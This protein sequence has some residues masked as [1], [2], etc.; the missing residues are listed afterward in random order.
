MDCLR[1]R[2]A[3]WAFIPQRLNPRAKVL[4]GCAQRFSPLAQ[5]M[6]T[7]P[8]C[9]ARVR[10]D[11]GAFRFTPQ[12]RRF[13]PHTMW[14]FAK[15]RILEENAQ[16]T[17]TRAGCQDP[18]H[19]QTLPSAYSPLL[20]LIDYNISKVITHKTGKRSDHRSSATLKGANMARWLSLKCSVL[21][22]VLGAGS[23][24]TATG[25]DG[26]D[27]PASKPTA[28][29]TPTNPFAGKNFVWDLSKDQDVSRVQW[30][31]YVGGLGDIWFL[32]GPCT[33]TLILPDGRRGTFSLYKAQLRRYGA[34]I[35]SVSIE[36][37]SETLTESRDR[38]RQ[39][40]SDWQISDLRELERW[41][42]KRAIDGGNPPDGEV[43]NVTA[44][45][46]GPLYTCG[47]SIRPTHDSKHPWF[48]SFGVAFPQNM[49]KLMPTSSGQ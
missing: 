33:I 48:V 25:C 17:P 10:F 6:G 22:A 42:Q 13:G 47:I 37:E 14:K 19:R 20:D 36:F 2:S 38:A 27:V 49:Q 24:G 40:A 3:R 43:N 11:A 30:P 21:I 18:S 29:T 9:N 8:Q 35:Y 34:Q 16:T 41:C 4:G 1:L 31:A 44:G 28:S 12:A 39:L 15:H 23:I 26:G 45:R 5:R 46:N 32:D 7:R